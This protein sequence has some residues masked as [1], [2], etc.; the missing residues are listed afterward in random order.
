M[1]PPVIILSRVAAPAAP[2]GSAPPDTHRACTV[3]RHPLAPLAGATLGAGT[4]RG[5]VHRDQVRG[6]YGRVVCGHWCQTLL[7]GRQQYLSAFP[8]VMT[9]C[10]RHPALLVHIDAPTRAQVAPLEPHGRWRVR[11]RLVP[12]AQHGCQQ[13]RRLAFRQPRLDRHPEFVQQRRLFLRGGL[14]P[15]GCFR[16]HQARHPEMPGI[17]F[18]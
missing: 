10:A 15:P 6:R 4:Q 2:R 3:V 18:R 14:L 1:G 9:A 17:V 8:A 13:I 16:L 5:M 7:T 11:T 12:V